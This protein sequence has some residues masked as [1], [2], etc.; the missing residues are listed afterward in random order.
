MNVSLYMSKSL[1]AFLLNLSM[2]FCNE[3]FKVIAALLGKHEGIKVV[4]WKYSFPPFCCNCTTDLYEGAFNQ[5]VQN[6]EHVW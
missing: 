3:W 5:H 6:P 4:V 1:K 2:H